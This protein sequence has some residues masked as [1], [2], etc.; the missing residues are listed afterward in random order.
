MKSKKIL[1]DISEVKI[2]EFDHNDVVRH[3]VSKLLGL[4]KKSTDDKGATSSIITK[5][6]LGISKIRIC[7]LKDN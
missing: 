4:I 6:G 7:M 5:H 3:P 1:K 2:V